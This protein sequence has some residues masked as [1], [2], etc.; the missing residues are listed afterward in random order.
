MSFRGILSCE[1]YFYI[2]QSHQKH[3]HLRALRYFYPLNRST[4]ANINNMGKGISWSAKEC[5]CTALTWFHVMNNATVG[6]D[7]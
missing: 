6:A 2:Q 3:F 4:R 1:K 7:Q 5:E